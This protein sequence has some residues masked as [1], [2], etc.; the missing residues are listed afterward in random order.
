MS[1]PNIFQ[2]NTFIASKQDY[3]ISLFELNELLDESWYQN[4]KKKSTS[5]EERVSSQGP[6]GFYIIHQY[7]LIFAYQVKEKIKMGDNMM[8]MLW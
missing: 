4:M 8:D 1:A 3:K 7:K 5:W 2:K 6:F